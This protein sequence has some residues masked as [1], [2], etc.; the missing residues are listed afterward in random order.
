MTAPATPRRPRRSD[1]F[2]VLELLVALGIM[3]FVASIVVAGA[4]TP[5]QRQDLAATAADVA[6]GLKMT[7]AAARRSNAEQVFLIDVDGRRYWAPG[8][9][10]P[11]RFPPTL[12]LAL[13]VPETERQGAGAARIRFFPDGSSTPATLTLRKGASSTALSVDWL[14][15]A[16]RV[17]ER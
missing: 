8:I 1:G 5:R 17:A 11:R 7:R 16:I 14:S 6:A 15:G 2:T 10:P 4:V 3:A 13:D 12:A 9:L